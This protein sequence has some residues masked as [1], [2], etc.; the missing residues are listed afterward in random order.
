[1]TNAKIVENVV[2]AELDSTMYQLGS[3]YDEAAPRVWREGHS[4]QWF[5]KSD[6]L[7]ISLVGLGTDLADALVTATRLIGE[8]IRDLL[9]YFGELGIDC[10]WPR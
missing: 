4:G 3:A 10:R 6:K 8:K 5:L 2:W 1:M 9:F 7:Q